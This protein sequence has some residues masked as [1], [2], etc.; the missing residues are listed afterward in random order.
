MPEY[1][2]R[3]LSSFEVENAHAFINIIILIGH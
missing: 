2:P 3:K 1:T